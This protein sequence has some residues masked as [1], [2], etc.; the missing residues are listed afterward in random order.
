MR[1]VATTIG[2]VLIAA[3]AQNPPPQTPAPPKTT[4]ERQWNHTI[5][6]PG[7]LAI[8][9]SPQRVFITDD[10]TGVEARAVTD[11]TLAWQA[12]LPS[13]L[14]V[15]VGGDQV[16]VASAGQ[17]HA[18]DEAT[19][20]V[21]W[22]RPLG[23]PAVALTMHGSGALTAAGYSVEAWST[24]GTS[25]WKTTLDAKVLRELLAVDGLQI[26]VGLT[27][28]TLVALDAKSGVVKW[29]KRPGTL[30]LAFA[31]SDGKVYFGGNDGNFHAYT[32][33]GDRKWMYHKEGVVGAPA[34]DDENVY[35]TLGDNTVV[36]HD[37]GN[38]HMRWRRPLE[39]R[40]ARGPMLS[41][42]NIVAILRSDVLV[43]MPRTADKPGP[44]P[45]APASGPPASPATAD[46]P[47]NR[48]WVAAPSVDGTQVFAVIQLENRTRVVVAYK[49]P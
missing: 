16:Y 45:P 26:Y 46:T 47:P 35:V 27:D 14:A 19:G 41:G 8:A 32:R 40:P 25:L 48:V 29:I 20:R 37:K 24:D 10:G 42:P 7:Q 12:E 13:D 49:R 3:A 23:A 30:P 5:E 18:L 33:D 39:N 11:G 17:I 9:V 2:C 36:A 31:A 4:F 43:T 21:R 22:A 28:Y 6:A 34:V 15:A 44:A 1:G 38:G